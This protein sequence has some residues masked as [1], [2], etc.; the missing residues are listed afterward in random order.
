MRR[1]TRP[2]E[3]VE[4]DDNA[5][6][7]LDR[8]HPNLAGYAAALVIVTDDELS[9]EMNRVV[10]RVADAA[11]QHRRIQMDELIDEFIDELVEQ[12]VDGSLALTEEA[13]R[14]AQFR[15][16]ML[17][18]HQVYTAAEIGRLRG[19]K[20]ADPSQIA[21]RWRSQRRIFSVAVRG[22]SV[23]FAFQFDEHLVPHPLIGS[24]LE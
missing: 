21:S 12:S 5:R 18:D 19:S 17:R 20:A 13:R 14:Q 22:K 16:R 2:V 8:R 3:V 11:N 1:P 4:L 24:V 7:V 9:C 10:R 6:R 23:Y 15:Q